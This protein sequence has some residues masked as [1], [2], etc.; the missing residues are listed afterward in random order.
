MKHKLAI[1]LGTALLLFTIACAGITPIMWSSVALAANYPTDDSGIM[2]VWHTIADDNYLWWC[3]L[4]ADIIDN[5]D[6]TW[7]I[8]SPQ[9]T[10]GGVNQAYID[11]DYY[12]YEPIPYGYNG[13]V[14]SLGLTPPT[15]DDLPHS[16]HI[17]KLV[18]V[19]GS[20]AKPATVTR[21]WHGMSFNISCLVSQSIVDMWIADD[22][23]VGDF[24]IVSF[25]D[26]H[27]NETELNLAIV[28]DKVYESWS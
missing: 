11:Y 9:F 23:N 22:L 25:I 12:H 10:A 21:K 27:P 2:I 20:K 1:I 14:A 19:D 3:D 6:G 8:Y 13:T 7:N 26:E 18:A 24:V 5:G 16:Q 28:V 15:A 17:G 4:T